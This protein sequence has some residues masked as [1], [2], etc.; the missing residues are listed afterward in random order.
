M[1]F[2][3]GPPS[4]NSPPTCLSSP[5]PYFAQPPRAQHGLFWPPNIFKAKGTKRR[6]FPKSL[7][8]KLQT[9]R[10]ETPKPCHY[11]SPDVFSRASSARTT[12]SHSLQVQHQELGWSEEE[13]GGEPWK[14]RGRTHITFWGSCPWAKVHTVTPS[15]PA[16]GS[17]YAREHRGREATPKVR[18]SSDQ[19]AS[20][21]G[22]PSL[23][24]EHLHLS[25]ALPLTRQRL[26]EPCCPS[27]LYPGGPWL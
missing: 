23:L 7:G 15:W 5:V 8:G 10:I 27:C 3:L 18:R 6:G 22:R 26:A 16:Q 11:P 19:A 9:G 2:A 14:A 13:R 12:P 24:Q 17:F 25:E 21:P 1:F 20:L 4:P